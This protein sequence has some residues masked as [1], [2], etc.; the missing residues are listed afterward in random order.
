VV[1]FVVYYT[2]SVQLKYDVA[3]L[4]DLEL[5]GRYLHL[6]SVPNAY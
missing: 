4:D 1:C 5:F 3:E 6:V 2:K